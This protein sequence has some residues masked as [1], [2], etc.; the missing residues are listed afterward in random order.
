MFFKLDTSLLTYA[1]HY[2][3]FT[4]KQEQISCI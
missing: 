4:F 3:Y 1:N 2:Y